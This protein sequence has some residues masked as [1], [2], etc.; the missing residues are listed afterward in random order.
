MSAPTVLV[1]GAGIADPAL[2]I[3]FNRNGYRVKKEKE[4]SDNAT[5]SAAGHR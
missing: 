4:M 3:W 2:A 1:S 5:G